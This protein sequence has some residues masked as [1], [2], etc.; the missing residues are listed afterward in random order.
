[1]PTLLVSLGSLYDKVN[2]TEPLILRALVRGSA[3]RLEP[4]MAALGS[5]ASNIGCRGYPILKP[6]F[7]LPNHTNH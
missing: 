7:A 3:E 1:M 5:E 4:A 6:K 2:H